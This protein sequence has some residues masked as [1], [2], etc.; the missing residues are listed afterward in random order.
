MGAIGAFLVSVTATKLRCILLARMIISL[1]LKFAAVRTS[2][3]MEF[4][5]EDGKRF[6]IT[7]E[8]SSLPGNSSNQGCFKIDTINCCSKIASVI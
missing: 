8:E 4:L 7:K 1:A 6:K 5:A 2:S 3:I